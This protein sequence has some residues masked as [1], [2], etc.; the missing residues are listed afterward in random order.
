MMN[1]Y[2]HHLH[3][4][5]RVWRRPSWLVW[6]RCRDLH[7]L[8]HTVTCMCCTVG[9]GIRYPG[10]SGPGGGDLHGLL[11]TV[12]CMCCVGYGVRYPGWCGP[13]GGDLHGLLH[14]VMF[15]CC[16][17]WHTPKNIYGYRIYSGPLRL[18]LIYLFPEKARS[19]IS[20][21]TPELLSAVL[22]NVILC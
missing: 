9:Y 14:T 13:S 1:T 3:V 6:T 20:K 5:C 16:R 7:G 18:L 10:W 8:L 19:C 22:R 12:M 4:L 17:V 15:M 21:A 2:I 11:H